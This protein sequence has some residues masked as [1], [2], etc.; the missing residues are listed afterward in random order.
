[1][2]CVSVCRYTAGLMDEALCQGQD[3]QNIRPLQALVAGLKA[4]STWANV[5]CLQE[6]RECTGG[7]VS[8]SVPIYTSYSLKPVV[9]AVVKNALTTFYHNELFLSR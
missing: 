2:V 8:A 4:Y 6:C 1:M 3:L 5:A 7:M 9:L